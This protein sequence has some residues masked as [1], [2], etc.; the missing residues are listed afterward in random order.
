MGVDIGAYHARIGS[1][2]ANYKRKNTTGGWKV[3]MD[4][5]QTWF[6]GFVLMVMDWMSGGKSRPASG[7]RENSSDS[8]IPYLTEYKTKIFS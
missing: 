1:F 4:G 7:T 8:N 2:A 5:W 3:Q 6:W